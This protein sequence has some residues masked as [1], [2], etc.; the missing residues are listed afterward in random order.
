MACTEWFSQQGIGKIWNQSPG[1]QRS[2]LEPPYGPIDKHRM[3]SAENLVGSANHRNR[4][5]HVPREALTGVIIQQT[6]PA[7]VQFGRQAVHLVF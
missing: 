4:R 3:I 6:M 1:I 5:Q 2:V 7:G